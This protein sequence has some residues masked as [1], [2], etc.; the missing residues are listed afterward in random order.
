M[1]EFPPQG[2]VPTASAVDGIQVYMPAPEK[3][4]D[5]PEVMEF[6]CPRCQATTAYSVADGGLRCAHCGYYEPPTA[7]VVGKGAQEFEFTVETMAVAGYA[8]GWG[9]ARQALQCRNCGATTSLPPGRLTHT[10]P[11]CGSNRVLQQDAPQEVL[12]PRFLIPF[13][14]EARDCRPIVRTWL[15]TSWMT[16]RTL[17]QTAVRD[18]NG[19]YLPY[20]TFDARAEADWKAEVGHQEQ[21]RYYD[22]GDKTWKTRTVTKWR[23]ESGHVREIFDD[24]LVA[25]TDHL[26]ATLLDRVQEYDTRALVTYD[27]QYLAGFLAQAYDVPLEAAWELGREQMRRRT[28]QA[29]R[30]QASTSQIRNFRMTLDFGE[31][32]WRYVLLPVYVA[33]YQYE[34]EPYQVMVNGQTGT[35]AG[36]RPVDWT[37]VWLVIGALVAPGGLLSLLGVLALALGIL[38]PPSLAVGGLLLVPGFFLLIV[39]G[40]IALIIMNKARGMDDA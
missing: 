8:H 33:V 37:K 28:R 17:Q 10:C 38:L 1:S 30:G 40:V 7:P 22:H 26:S 23:W 9:E 39:G 36:Q 15:G 27:P 32:S 18:F 19:I 14:L 2:Y 11:F 13:K 29:C 31:E 3:V 12:R 21:E 34:G 35:I 24:L 16:P 6:K 25:G 4:E 5:L 20:W